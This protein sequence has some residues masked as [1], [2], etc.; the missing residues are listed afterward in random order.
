MRAQILIVAVMAACVA[1]ASQAGAEGQVPAKGP[2]LQVCMPVTSLSSLAGSAMGLPQFAVG[3]RMEALTFGLGVGLARAGY[4]NKD[5]HDGFE[6]K[7]EVGATLL[8]FSPQ[9]AYDF[10]RSPDASTVANLKAA[11]HV[12]MLFYREKHEDHYPFPYVSE[13]YSHENTG[14]GTLLGFGLAVGGDHYLSPNFALGLEMGA[15]GSYA[16]GVHDKDNKNNKNGFA[17]SIFYG[18]IRSTIVF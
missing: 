15:D 16:L 4:S 2:M 18:A 12:G 3:F 13:S 8:Q 6:H 10:W 11:V 17:T 9:A 7:Y 1:L 14:S 5:S